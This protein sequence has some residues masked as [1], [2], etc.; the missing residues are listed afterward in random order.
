MAAHRR[1]IAAIS[2]VGFVLAIGILAFAFRGRL[3]APLL[4]RFATTA[5][6]AAPSAATGTDAP[7]TSSPVAGE[8]R[9]D[10]TIDPQ[11]QQLIGV[12]L[13][14]VERGPVIS[15]VRTTG[16][17]RYDETRL[18][19]VN[20]KLEGWI[21]D[22]YVDYTGQPVTKGERLFTLYSPELLTTQNEYLLALK[23][24]DRMQGS[25]V[26]DARE[27][28]QRLVD[29]A[30]E[31]LALWDLSPEQ[32]K[33][34]E[35]TRQPVTAVTF[36]APAAGYVIEK[37]AVRGMHVMPGQ[38]LY[39]VADLSR[40]WVEADVYEQEMAQA[41]VG[42][43][44]TVT[45]DAYPGE[46]FEGRAIYIHPFVEE[47]TRTLKVRFE[48]ANTRGRLRPGMYAN[49]QLQGAG[50]LGLT[51]PANAVLDSGAQ[52]LVFVAQ[53]DGYFT[54]RPVKVGRNL[55]DRIEI[56]QG[57]KDGEQVATG[58]TFFLDSESQLR[59]GLQNYEAPAAAK[60]APPAAGPI[61][62]IAFRSQPD[63]PRTGESLFEVAVKDA[64]GQPV[65]DGE[66]S[67]ELFMP[68]MPTMNMPAMRNETKLP[69]AGGGVY[70]GPG[71]VMMAGR[72]DVTVAV[73][74][75]GRL[76]GRKQLAMV[77]R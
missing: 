27:Y 15:S 11:R 2:L 49:V 35:E 52:Q 26:A 18:T 62:D 63:P 53:G 22:L 68:A 39:R 20:V 4:R 43:R 29:A 46:S 58:A 37:A 3:H 32:I 12:R 71:Q 14:R 54:P 5:P 41:R 19:D 50:G 25:Q 40:V 76:I 51:V 21:R 42:Q 31:R 48:F 67:V 10:V 77:A 75:G 72:W 9:G 59:A 33:A 7:P 34:L 45:L 6:M 24:R 8:P 17:V 70:R 69:H 55:G 28:A 36:A 74:R 73:N 60:G 1:A 65:T 30:R 64:S 16:V 66:V 44:A 38:T 56:V 23:T 13:T 61:V 47:N 57:V